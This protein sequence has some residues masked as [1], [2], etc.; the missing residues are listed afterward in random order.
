MANFMADAEV[1]TAG[2]VVAPERLEL[3]CVPG[4][5]EPDA[6]ELRA[7]VAGA[8]VAGT[9]CCSWGSRCSCTRRKQENHQ[10][11]TYNRD[12]YSILLAFHLV[13]PKS[14]DLWY[15]RNSD[16][17]NLSKKDWLCW[18]S[19]LFLHLDINKFFPERKDQFLFSR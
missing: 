11:H 18:N 17:S 13:P 16:I 1:F 4:L 6:A 12:Q 14:I 3:W 10:E 8:A 7:A 5:P 9:G 15:L 2:A 19:F